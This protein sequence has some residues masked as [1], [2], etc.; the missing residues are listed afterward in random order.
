MANLAQTVNVLQALILTEGDQMVLTPTYHVFDLYKAHQD[1]ERVGL[2][3]QGQDTGGKEGVPAISA[4]A[5]I[6]GEA[7]TITVAHTGLAKS[8][9]VCIEIAGFHATGVSG[10]VLS[11]RM[12]A[13]NGFGKP[14]RVWIQAMEGVALKDNCVHCTLAPCSVAEVTVRG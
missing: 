10:R 1:A 9:P 2:F 3:V 5:S 8:Q 11:G 13:Y 12:D 4:S 6:R 14:P 7:L